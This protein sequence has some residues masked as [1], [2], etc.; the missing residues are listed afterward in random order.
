MAKNNLGENLLHYTPA[1][2]PAPLASLAFFA[3]SATSTKKPSG[4]PARAGRA[5]QNPCQA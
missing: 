5:G 1:P 3:H 2:T 4:A